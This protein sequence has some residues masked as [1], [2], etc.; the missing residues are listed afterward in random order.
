H[1]EQLI[2]PGRGEELAVGREG[3][4]NHL[5][6]GV[7]PDLLMPAQVPHERSR[8]GVPELHSHVHLRAPARKAL[9][10]R[11]EGDRAH[12]TARVGP[13]RPEQGA[14]PR[15]VDPDPPVETAARYE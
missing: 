2:T 14:G 13:D 10:V 1:Q 5:D 7:A 15:V 8:R 12:A 4:G 6:E 3:D 9:A 11:R